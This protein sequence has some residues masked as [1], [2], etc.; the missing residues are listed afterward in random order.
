MALLQG[1]L[2]YNP[3]V[4][5][6]YSVS[7][8]PNG[9][10]VAVISLPPGWIVLSQSAITYQGP[11]VGN[12]MTFSVFCGI[13]GGQICVS[14]ECI[15]A[16]ANPVCITVTP[17]QQN[18]ASLSIC[19][20]AF[21]VATIDTT[22]WTVADTGCSTFELRITF[23]DSA[24]ASIALGVS[25][26]TS[27]AHATI[28]LCMADLVAQI[29]AA[30]TARPS[31]NPQGL[32]PASFNSG[33]FSMVTFPTPNYPTYSDQCGSN[34]FI[35]IT[36]PT[37]SCVTFSPTNQALF[38][39]SGSVVP[40]FGPPSITGSPFICTGQQFSL[41]VTFPGGIPSSYQLVFPQA[42]QLVGKSVQSLDTLLLTFI[43]DSNGGIVSVSYL[44]STG[45]QYVATY[46]LVNDCFIGQCAAK[47]LLSS[48]CNDT[49]P[50][51]V[52][53]NDYEKAEKKIEREMMNKALALLTTY[54]LQKAVYFQ[55]CLQSDLPALQAL[56][57]QIKSI[58]IRCGICPKIN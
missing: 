49:D 51:C 47:Q 9:C 15:V 50:C 40:C 24:D 27:S 6:T 16:P 36:N 55:D 33:V 21:G 22:A 54:S 1:N 13:Q 32:T 28:A 7:Q 35:T 52:E 38:L 58:L 53:C 25:I 57:L 2:T 12:V 48:F 44:N 23:S 17:F 20:S 37:G 56:L 3:F 5:E 29:N 43:P 45:A 39:G 42:W 14:F 8:I 11:L 18:Y 30:A 31:K 26:F 46:Q 10:S 4:T 41:L 34:T 19:C